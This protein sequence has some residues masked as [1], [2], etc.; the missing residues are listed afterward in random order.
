MS[1]K[2]IKKIEKNGNQEKGLKTLRGELN[3]MIKIFQDKIQ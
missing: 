1:Y 3:M 2:E